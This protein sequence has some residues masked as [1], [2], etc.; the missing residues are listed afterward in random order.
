MLKDDKGDEE[1]VSGAITPE[2]VDDVRLV[3]DLKA[4]M[5]LGDAS[6]KNSGRVATRWRYRWCE[7]WKNCLVSLG[8]ARCKA[9]SREA[10]GALAFTGV[11]LIPYLLHS[12]ARMEILGVP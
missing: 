9:G 4:L 3:L 12:G 1:P 7:H 5:C 11:E 6:L 2:A 10:I 8:A